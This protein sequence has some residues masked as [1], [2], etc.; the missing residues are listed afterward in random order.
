M[1]AVVVAKP[2]ARLVEAD[3]IADTRS[4]IAGFKVLRRVLLVM[5]CP[6]TRWAKC[7]K[8]GCGAVL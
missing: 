4:R 1:A 5:N 8:I 2:A 7:R 3:I 6:A